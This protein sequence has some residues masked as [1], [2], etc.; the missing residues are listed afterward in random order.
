MWFPGQH[1]DVGGGSDSD[2]GIPFMTMA[3]M[4]DKLNG[5]KKG[6]MLQFDRDYFDVQIFRLITYYS[7][8]VSKGWFGYYD[9]LA[10]GTRRPWGLGEFCVAAYKW[11]S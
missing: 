2:H 4:M 7:N 9:I 6:P 1:E 11:L 3:W 5:D 8:H 10:N